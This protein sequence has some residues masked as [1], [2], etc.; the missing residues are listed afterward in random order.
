LNLNNFRNKRK[1]FTIL[2]SAHN[3]SEIKFKEK[4]GVNLIFVSP[5]FLILFLNQLFFD[6][7]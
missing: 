5:L 2:G 3:I 1:N 7:F 6:S 4:Q